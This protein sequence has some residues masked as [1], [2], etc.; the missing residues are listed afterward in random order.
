[1]SYEPKW[2]DVEGAQHSTKKDEIE[3]LESTETRRRG[4]VFSI[5][6]GSRRRMSISDDVFGEITEK[7]PNYRNVGALGSP[8]ETA[9]AYVTRLVGWGQL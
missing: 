5:G 3:N 6:H 4:S 7:G 2:D 8:R 9:A 1:M